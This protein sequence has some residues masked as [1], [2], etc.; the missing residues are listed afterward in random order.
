MVFLCNLDWLWTLSHPVL[1]S[2]CA[3]AAA[4]HYA[5]LHCITHDI[6]YDV[7]RVTPLTLQPTEGTR[8][9]IS[10]MVSE[11]FATTHQSRIWQCWQPHPKWNLHCSPFCVP[12]TLGGFLTVLLTRDKGRSFHLSLPL[13]D[14]NGAALWSSGPFCRWLLCNVITNLLEI[15]WYRANTLWSRLD[16][17]IT[18]CILTYTILT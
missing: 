13:C 6:I 4:D 18:T 16:V 12:F 14:L 10:F 3:I 5:Q 2:E 15:D 8:P 11:S 7:M 1:A 17:N 9:K